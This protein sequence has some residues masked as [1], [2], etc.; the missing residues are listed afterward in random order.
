MKRYSKKWGVVFSLIFIVLTIDD[1]V[2]IFYNK[3]AYTLRMIVR[4][5]YEQRVFARLKQIP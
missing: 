3:N 4:L 2:F 5:Y 1:I